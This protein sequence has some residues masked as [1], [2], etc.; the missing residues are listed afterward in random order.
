MQVPAQSAALLF[1]CEHDPLAGAP[2]LEGHSRIVHRR[3]YLLRKGLKEPMV[4]WRELRLTLAH[5]EHSH[6]LCGV[7]ESEANDLLDWVSRGGSVSLLLAR[8]IDRCVW[9]AK[10]AAHGACQDRREQLLG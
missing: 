1:A 3:R 9:D 8:Q 4:G 2:Q 5:P 10:G 7:H 6:L